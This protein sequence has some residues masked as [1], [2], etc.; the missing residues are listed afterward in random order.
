MR[1]AQQRIAHRAADAPGFEAGAA[2]RA[3]ISMTSGGG[4][5]ELNAC[6]P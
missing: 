6:G 4:L 1:V 3:A 2:K 5:S